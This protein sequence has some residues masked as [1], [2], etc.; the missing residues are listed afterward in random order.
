MRFRFGRHGQGSPIPFRKVHCLS[1]LS[2]LGHSVVPAVAHD[3]TSQLEHRFGIGFSPE[4][5]VTLETQ[6]DHA[7]DAAFDRPAPQGKPETAKGWI[8][9]TTSVTMFL[10]IIQL[11]LKLFNL[12]IRGHKRCQERMAL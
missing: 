2:H 5:A 11:R 4:D 8:G 12:R 3:E 7:T 1:K 10:K 6:V 9:Q